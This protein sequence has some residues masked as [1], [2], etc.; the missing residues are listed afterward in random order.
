MRFTGRWKIYITKTSEENGGAERSYKEGQ[1]EEDPGVEEV[2]GK[3]NK[4]CTGMKAG[5]EGGNRNVNKGKGHDK[6]RWSRV[7]GVGK[8]TL[9][10]KG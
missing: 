10:E 2:T 5:V 3:V 1:G 4:T 8:E 7:K 9:K 6:E